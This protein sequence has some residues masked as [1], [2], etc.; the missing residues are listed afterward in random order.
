MHQ[1]ELIILRSLVFT[2]NNL[3][4]LIEQFGEETST[5]VFYLMTQGLLTCCSL[6]GIWQNITQVSITSRGLEAI[7]VYHVAKQSS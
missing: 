4:R 7:G 1:R 6:R 2:P 3:R 5:S